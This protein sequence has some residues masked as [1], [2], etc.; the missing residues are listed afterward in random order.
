[1]IKRSVKPH[2]YRN[3]N[4]SARTKSR[5]AKEE[6]FNRNIPILNILFYI[7][8]G[9]MLKRQLVILARIFYQIN[10]HR[11]NDMVSDLLS[12]GLLIRK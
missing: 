2:M 11:T 4:I 9:F 6:C 8:H 3:E 12:C 7:G 10:E 1:M 5:L